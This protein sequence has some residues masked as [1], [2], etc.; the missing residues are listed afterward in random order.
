MFLESFLR[1]W[2]DF[3]IVSVDHEVLKVSETP[4][5]RFLRCW[6]C[7]RWDTTTMDGMDWWVSREEERG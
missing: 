1:S 5:E 2:F 4:G 3:D 6:H 7:L